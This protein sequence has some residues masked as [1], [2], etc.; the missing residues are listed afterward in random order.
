M[1]WINLTADQPNI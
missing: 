1:C